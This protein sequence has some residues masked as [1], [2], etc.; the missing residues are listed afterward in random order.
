MTAEEEVPNKALSLQFL[1]PPLRRKPPAVRG[2]FLFLVYSV[3][4]AAAFLLARC[5]R[6]LRP[7][8]GAPLGGAQTRFLA[9]NQHPWGPPDEG[10]EEEDEFFSNTLEAC[11]DMES[12]LGLPPVPSQPMPISE[13]Q[14]ISNITWDLRDAAAL[15]EHEKRE[16]Q[17]TAQGFL[18]A[19]GWQ[20]A[21]AAPIHPGP[22]AGYEGDHWLRPEGW[23]WEEEEG[24][25]LEAPNLTTTPSYESI[26]GATPSSQPLVS[27]LQQ[28]PTIS[29]A[30]ATA[31]TA[32]QGWQQ[33]L[34]GPQGVGGPWGAF[35]P[36]TLSA[37]DLYGSAVAPELF[38]QQ[39]QQQF[40]SSQEAA[41]TVAAAAAQGWPQQHGGP[42]GLR[43]P[44]ET[45]APPVPFAGDPHSLFASPGLFSVQ[46][47]QQQLSTSQPVAAAAP[48]AQGW[49][50]QHGETQGLKGPQGVLDSPGT[51]SPPV[52]SAEDLHSLLALAES[53]SEQQQQQQP[54]TSQAAAAA[55]A[56]APVAEGWQQEHGGPQGLE[57]PQ[58]VV[59]SPRALAPPVPSAGNLHSLS[60]SP[61]LFPALQQQQQLS[62]SQAAPVAHGWQQ[63]HGGSQEVEEPQ[64]VVGFPEALAPPSPSAKDLHGSP[65][66]SDLLSL[67]L[68][69]QPS[70]RQGAGAAG[71]AAGDSEA[72]SV[73]SSE[74]EGD[75]EL[76]PSKKSKRD[77][78]EA[79]KGSSMLTTSR[80]EPQ[81]PAWRR[82]FIERAAALK[83]KK[84][85]QKVTLAL[86]NFR[87]ATSSGAGPSQ[88]MSPSTSGERAAG[89]PSASPRASTSSGETASGE[90]PSATSQVQASDL[91]ISE[92]FLTIT[93]NT[94]E[95]VS[96]AHP[97]LPVPA[98]APAHYRLP[99]V[100][101]EAIKTEFQVDPALV[102]P[103]NRGPW[104][105][106][107]VIKKLFLQPVLNAK[108]VEA[109]VLRCQALV[110]HL[111]TKC[112]SK[113]AH[114]DPYELKEKLGLRFIVM[115][116][117]VN[118]IQ[119]L[120]PAMNPHKWFPQ[121]VATVPMESTPYSR[122]RAH[123]NT[124]V[125]K[126][127][128]EA[129]QDLTKGRRPSLQLTTDIKS[130]LFSPNIAPRNIPKDIIKE[131]WPE[132]QKPSEE[133]REEK[134]QEK[135]QQESEE[136]PSDEA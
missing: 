63:D 99:H 19:P 101:P 62:T 43:A 81:L 31:V 23:M 30:A 115:E 74:E 67:L 75:I 96:F 7:K 118:C 104:D 60:A 29:N 10:D 52:L 28:Q 83:E 22:M 72:S 90:S 134:P 41:A 94:G 126:L 121:L 116:T 136:T 109:I 34:A 87:E 25:P 27:L 105:H 65:A 110:R 57:G 102:G 128:A 36:P 129:L 56:V 49:Q 42:Q 106:L 124:R 39:Q 88:E 47:Q 24:A 35:A 2:V 51:L 108:D 14:A 84:D 122:R 82:R 133:P 4:A 135:E 5:F 1:A 95:T 17:Q 53:L 46:Q 69:R 20:P 111:M 120:G 33:Q 73:S 127:L 21:A 8:E 85:G 44:S 70:S 131:W 78:E 26:R 113:V 68:Q 71:G 89:G 15:F 76:P 64:G 40:S 32:A 123:V 86:L 107:V 6:R 77:K 132:F 79:K 112:V 91:V 45:T 117:L 130:L 80:N 50:Q 59:G 98:E 125:A 11:L 97:P 58:A 12:D 92:G 54:S 9:G 18:Q 3:A 16:A 13:P 37:E 61:G 100:P 38:S 103:T 119:V 55:A 66:S 114:T 48:V 93:M